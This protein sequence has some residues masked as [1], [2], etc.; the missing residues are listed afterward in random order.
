M[1]ITRNDLKILTNYGRVNLL[2][3]PA[4]KPTMSTKVLCIHGYCCDARIFSY[5][6]FEMSKRGYDTYAIDLL[7]HGKSDGRRGD[8]DFD[9]TI[10]A[11]KEIIDK[12]RGQSTFFLL[13]HS[14]GCTYALWYARK[15]TENIDG[16]LLMSPYIRIK[17]LKC[18]GGEAIPSPSTFLKLLF[19]RLLIPSHR[20][21][22]TKVV[23]RSI[24]SKSETQQM[25]NDPE[26]NYYYSYKYIIDVIGFRNMNAGKLADIN[27]PVHLLHGKQDKNVFPRVSEEFFKRLKS[28]NKCLTL[29]ECDH[30]FYHSIFYNQED[31]R[32]NECERQQ[33]IGKITEWF[34]S[35]RN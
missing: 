12:I 35:L 1:M 29:F 4:A 18:G 33:V 31:D 8:P 11:M 17:G 13:G 16:I 26:I 28:R 5:I 10:K 22:A 7:G 9:K 24:V 19:F 25:I 23:Q 30:W 21:S 3:F 6:G 34:K 14:L 20:I 32:Y 27:I 2:H 15:F